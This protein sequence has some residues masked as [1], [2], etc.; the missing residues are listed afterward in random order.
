MENLRKQF[1]N[2][3]KELGEDIKFF[4]FLIENCINCRYEKQTYYQFIEKIAI[5]LSINLDNPDINV[6]GELHNLNYSF[7]ILKNIYKV[8]DIDSIDYDENFLENFNYDFS[9]D[10]LPFL[11][12]LCYIAGQVLLFDDM[13][14]FLVVFKKILKNIDTLN[15][16]K[17]NKAKIKDS[18]NKN[19]I[20]IF[21][22]S[23][24]SS[25]ND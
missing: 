7:T 2:D 5:G 17:E 18:I 1:L 8:K 12:E 25:L 9:S 15:L 20:N 23:F 11:E 24:F 6:E 3:T 13:N 19:L 10:F 4:I 14:N 22:D 21:E 16:E